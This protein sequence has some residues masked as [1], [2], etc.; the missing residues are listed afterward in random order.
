MGEKPM[1]PG[2]FLSNMDG[3]DEHRPEI[4]DSHIDFDSNIHHIFL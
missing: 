3:L 4:F 1:D 2:N